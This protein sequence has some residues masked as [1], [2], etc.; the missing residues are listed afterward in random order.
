VPEPLLVEVE[1]AIVKLKSYKSLSTDHFPA[2]LIKA[3]GEKLCSEL[4]KL[5]VLYGIRNNCHGTGG[6]V[7][8]CQFIKGVIRL[9][10]I[11]IEDSPS[12]Q[13][14]TK[15]YPTFFWPG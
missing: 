7:L 2:E 11:I 13:L 15:Y 4:H 8:F 3:G 12:Y 10:V 1:I 6:S 14:P 9:I 5:F